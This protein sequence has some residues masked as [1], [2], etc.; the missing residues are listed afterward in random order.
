M[1][2]TTLEAHYKN[3]FALRHHHG[4]SI[5]EINDLYPF[6]FE[7]YTGLAID[8]NNELAEKNNKWLYKTIDW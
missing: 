2:H 3:I 1:I 8:Y 6:E 5:T 7:I 4:Y